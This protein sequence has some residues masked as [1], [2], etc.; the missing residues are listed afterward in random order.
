MPADEKHCA[1]SRRAENATLY[2]DSVLMTPPL[3][4]SYKEQLSTDKIFVFAT[5]PFLSSNNYAL[6][7]KYS[8]VFFSPSSK[9]TDGLYFKTLVILVISA[10]VLNTSPARTG[11]NFGLIFFP[12]ILFKAST[13]YRTVCEAPL[14][15]LT[16]S[17]LM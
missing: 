1:A 11:S 15:T 16:T 4:Q 9:L 10:S 14:A 13:K 5:L 3:K 6:D 12:M 17:C 2:P 7:L 8:T